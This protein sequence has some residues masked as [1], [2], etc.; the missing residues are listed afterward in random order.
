MI[1]K[2][3][4]GVIN[5]HKELRCLFCGC[6]IRIFKLFRR[7]PLLGFKNYFESFSKVLYQIVGFYLCKRNV[8]SHGDC[9]AKVYL[10]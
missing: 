3:F 5:S 7:S 10:C 6:F 4:L 9:F 8:P 1:R 2:N